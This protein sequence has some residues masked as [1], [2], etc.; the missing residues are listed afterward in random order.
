VN[1]LAIDMTPILSPGGQTRIET[2]NLNIGLFILPA[3]GTGGPFTA[4]SQHYYVD[5][6]VLTPATVAP[7]IGSGNWKTPGSGTWSG[8]IGANW[9]PA[10]PNA[11]DNAATFGTFGGTINVPTTVTVAGGV[12]VG[13]INFDNTNSFTINGSAITLNTATT[14]THDSLNAIN[15]L[16][17]S[18]TINSQVVKGDNANPITFNVVQ[19]SSTL[20]IPNLF[21]QY[22]TF[23]KEGAGKLVV[24][25]AQNVTLFVN[26][27]TVQMI[28]NGTSAATNFAYYLQIAPTARLD[29]TNNNFVYQYGG[30]TAVQDTV[31]SMLK[32]GFAGGAWNGV[33]GITSSSAAAVSGIHKT[34]IDT[35]IPPIP[36]SPTPCRTLP[37][38]PSTPPAFSCAI[39]CWATLTLI[40]PLI[41]AI[42]ISSPRTSTAAGSTGLPAIL[43]MTRW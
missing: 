32:N 41:P 4:L 30:A 7:T 12:T 19:A 36:A 24:N 42:S 34:G 21:A 33:G 8:S 43:T 20:T 25:R 37:V 40:S 35:W 2:T 11:P 6:V 28:P 5:N 29:V 10:V 23:T 22:Y 18:H 9:D 3:F 15:V 16:S 13:T 14:G 27:G 39:P 26:G 31:R 38:E 17:G 1:H